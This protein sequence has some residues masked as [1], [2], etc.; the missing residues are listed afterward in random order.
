MKTCYKCQQ[1]KDSSEFGKNR[2]KYDGLS[3][4]CRACKRKKDNEYSAKNREKAKLRA[5]EWYRNNKDRALSNRKISSARW[6]KEN[7]A[8]N[9]AKASKYRAAKLGATPLWLTEED[10]KAIDVEYS[11]ALWTSEVMKS[12]YHVDHIVPLQG[13][14]VCGLHVPWNLQVIPASINISKGNRIAS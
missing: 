2:S 6:A 5:S 4:E 7:P 8:K 14:Q 12:S 11:L 9:N 3:T 1:E 10:I 13:K